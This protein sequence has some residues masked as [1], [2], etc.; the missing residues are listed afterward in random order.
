MSY[1]VFARVLATATLYFELV[2]EDALDLDTS[3][4]AMEEIA[5][6]LSG[7]SPEEVLALDAA[8]QQVSQEYADEHKDTVKNMLRDYGL[9]E[10]PE[11][12]TDGPT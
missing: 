2:D 6:D 5:S 4:R 7:L 12:A 10:D 1:L 3:V 11:D 9:I 8:L